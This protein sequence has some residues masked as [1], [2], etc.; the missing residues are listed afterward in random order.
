MQIQSHGN[1][2]EIIRNKTP[3]YSFRYYF[4]I[5][6][7]SFQVTKHW[8]NIVEKDPLKIFP[9]PESNLTGVEKDTCFIDAS[10]E[11][12]SRTF[13]KSSSI[14]QNSI[15]GNNVKITDCIIMNNVVIKDG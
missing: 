13:V 2:N 11:M 6:F 3:D 10:V 9:K 8:K 12:G 4:S 1:Y 14:G 15:I 7:V 5:L